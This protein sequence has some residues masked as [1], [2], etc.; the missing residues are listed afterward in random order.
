MTGSFEMRLSMQEVCLVDIYIYI[1]ICEHILRD[2]SVDMDSSS[3]WICWT[4]LAW[5]AVRMD[6]LVNRNS[7]MGEHYRV[8]LR[9]LKAIDVRQLYAED[10]I[11]ESPCL[12]VWCWQDSMCLY[13]YN[14]LQYH[15]PQNKA[16]HYI[17]AL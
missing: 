12:N 11:D 7:Q 2:P 4:G 10:P 9:N 16:F 1:D 5:I 6:C 13:T 17:P 14:V 15:F 3:K 8:W